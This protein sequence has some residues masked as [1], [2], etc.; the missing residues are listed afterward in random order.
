M[1]LIVK[2]ER[3]KKYTKFGKWY[4]NETEVDMYEGKQISTFEHNF[5]SYNMSVFGAKE[6]RQYGYTCNGYKVIKNFNTL[7]LERVVTT[8]D[9][10]N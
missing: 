10:K 6:T 9:Y 5:F 4:T 1:K 7:G 2:T 3:Q 8:F